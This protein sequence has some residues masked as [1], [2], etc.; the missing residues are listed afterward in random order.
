MLEGK[1]VVVTGG[2]RDFG[3]AVSILMA[4]HGARVDLCARRLSSAEETSAT[5]KQNGGHARPHVCDMADP[6]SIRAFAEVL[7]SDATPIDILVLS[8]AQWLEGSLTD[9]SDEEIVSTVASGLTGSILLTKALL[10]GLHSANGAD[11]LVMGS[12]CALPGYV[13]SNA[14]PAFYAAKHGIKGFCEIMSARLRADDIRVTGFYPPDFC[15]TDDAAGERTPDA[16]QGLL[17]SSSIW[18]AMQFVLAQ[19]R[20]CLVE[21]INFRGATR[22]EL[23][24]K[25]KERVISSGELRKSLGLNG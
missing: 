16:A 22:A 11:I 19:P 4:R 15:T 21:A 8:A 10:P 23:D 3:R 20:N 18:N 12:A 14:H 5:I 1:R 6:A 25:G 17:H 24:D 7:L 2:G 13:E 9:A